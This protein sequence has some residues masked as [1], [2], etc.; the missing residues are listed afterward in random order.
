MVNL[1]EYALSRRRAARRQIRKMCTRFN[2]IETPHVS[3]VICRQSTSLQR[4]RIAVGNLDAVLRSRIRS[5]TL[6]HRQFFD[7]TAPQQPRQSEVAF[8]AARLV[9]DSVLF[10]ALLD[11]ILLG[12]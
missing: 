1:I 7:A 2:L 9:I 6:C 12:G 10:V 11:K 8:D 4:V 3:L 5:A